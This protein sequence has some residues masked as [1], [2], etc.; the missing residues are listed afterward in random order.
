MKVFILQGVSG[1]GKS[2]LAN[3][4][5]GEICSADSFFIKDGKYQFDISKLSEA[6]GKCLKKFIDMVQNNIKLIV[7]DNTNTTI[8]EIAPY[9]AVA[10]AYNYD[11]EIISLHCP[12]EIAAKR[13]V[14]NVPKKSIEYMQERIINMRFPYYWKFIHTKY[15]CGEN[16]YE[17]MI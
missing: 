1:S 5:R 12:V 2:T 13:N 4:L 8:E 15:I 10:Q 3:S 6:H 7:V 9:F 16:G 14:H 17:S 11:I